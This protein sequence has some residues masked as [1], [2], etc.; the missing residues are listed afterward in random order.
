MT[1]MLAFP[2]QLGG[3][4]VANPVASLTTDQNLSV[5]SK[6]N[7]TCSNSLSNFITLT[8][9]DARLDVAIYIYFVG[10]LMLIVSLHKSPHQ[11]VAIPHIAQV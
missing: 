9:D 11:I 3:L 4:G 1:C 8:E 7:P 2:I 6:P 5:E 10:N